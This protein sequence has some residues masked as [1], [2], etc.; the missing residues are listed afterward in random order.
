VADKDLIW[1]LLMVVSK[2]KSERIECRCKDCRHTIY[3]RIHIIEWPD[4]RIEP[5]GSGC[6]KRELG[7]T[8]RA[9]GM[10]P[11][12]PGSWGEAM[13]PELRA[14]IGTR[15]DLFIEHF[16]KREEDERKAREAMEADRQRFLNEVEARMQE[17]LERAE[18]KK[19]EESKRQ[20]ESHTDDHSQ[21]SFDANGEPANL[22]CELCGTR[23][24][25]WWTTSVTSE[26]RKCKC[27]ACQ[28]RG[29]TAV[30]E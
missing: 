12:Y 13:P 28:Q 7:H 19:A 15:T 8:L 5:W 2:P 22:L 6:Y 20:A 10:K 24:R 9:R 23:T 25:E 30:R 26:G 4:G 3:R 14:L 11:R 29:P 18:R 21:S 27:N 16:R 17:R 1:N